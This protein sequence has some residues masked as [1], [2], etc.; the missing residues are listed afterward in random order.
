MG[1]LDSVEVVCATCLGNDWDVLV[2][3]R[4]GTVSESELWY[5]FAGASI[6]KV[7]AGPASKTYAR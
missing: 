1:I 6:A 2:T 5:T 7:E 4:V 3:R